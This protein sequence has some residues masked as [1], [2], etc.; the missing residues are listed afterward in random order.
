MESGLIPFGENRREWV[1][2]L[3][4]LWQFDQAV[5]VIGLTLN[6]HSKN[7]DIIKSSPVSFNSIGAVNGGWDTI[8]PTSDTTSS[9]GAWNNR[10]WIDALADLT[11]FTDPTDKT[12]DQKIRKNAA[13][14]SFRVVADTPNTYYELSHLSLLYTY[15]G[16]GV[17][18]LSRRGVIKI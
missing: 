17:E 5:G 12:A 3:K 15:I 1:H 4:A 11:D 10:N 14:V 6:V 2:V 13:Y 16:V 9:E 8:R 7:G 18:F